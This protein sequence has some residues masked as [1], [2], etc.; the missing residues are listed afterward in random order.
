MGI[1][2]EETA[3]IEELK[4]KHVLPGSTQE[5]VTALAKILAT[6]NPDLIPY[7]VDYLVAENRTVA[8]EASRTVAGLFQKI[9]LHRFIYFDVLMREGEYRYGG[10]G[11]GDISPKKLSKFSSFDAGPYSIILA[12]C[13][14]HWNGF[15]REQATQLLAE[16][17]PEL[18]LPLALVRATDWVD[19]VA[20]VA[21]RTS[22]KLIESRPRQELIQTLPI[23]SLL[24][25]R[26]RRENGEL[27]G[28]VEKQLNGPEMYGH[29]LQKLRIGNFRIR[30]ATIPF[31]FNHPNLKFVEAFGLIMRDRDPHNRLLAARKI[32]TYISQENARRILDVAISDSYAA[33]RKIGL[34]FY[35]KYFPERATERLQDLL[36]DDN[37]NIRE[38][39]RFYLSKN[40]KRDFAAYYRKALNDD[41]KLQNAIA[42][43]GETGVK[44]DVILLLPWVNHDSVRVARTAL[45]AIDKL[46]GQ[47]FVG[48]FLENLENPR[49]GIA[50]QSAYL[51]RRYTRSCSRKVLWEKFLS[52]PT[53]RMKRRI[54]HLVYGLPKWDAILLLLKA[55]HEPIS[56]IREL[57]DKLIKSWVSGF[58]ISFA[59]PHKEQ[60]T[61]FAE[62]LP[63]YEPE[64]RDTWHEA[65][66][67]KEE[68]EF[69]LAS[70]NGQGRGSDIRSPN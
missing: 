8:L 53:I 5:Q 6:D 69:I 40:Q 57:S 61:E 30:R 49:A 66:K 48:L 4:S 33:V 11:W 24:K 56:E 32:Q 28:F 64:F 68:L 15:I 39:A 51:L 60:I 10:G 29:M 44:D 47:D 55:W 9:P 13:T 27:L 43:L 59:T 63:D 23:V 58:N 54:L 65:V 3:L 2:L 22:I 7:I 18:A 37:R 12:I 1:T 17:D 26:T 20:A 52:V 42:S 70:L 35:L 67:Q 50:R 34:D 62:L 25:D 38:S 45:L 21:K 16:V 36:L 19:Q 31:I 41:Y 14:F 46:A